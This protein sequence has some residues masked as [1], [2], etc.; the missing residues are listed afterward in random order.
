[1]I[2]SLR[3]SG[4]YGLCTRELH[5][6]RTCY[7]IWPDFSGNKNLNSETVQKWFLWNPT[8]EYTGARSNISVYLILLLWAGGRVLVAKTKKTNKH[9][10]CTIMRGSRVRSFGPRVHRSFRQLHDVPSS[11]HITPSA[12]YVHVRFH[13]VL[14][15]RIDYVLGV[16][17]VWAEANRTCS[18]PIKRI[19]KTEIQFVLLPSLAKE[20]SSPKGPERFWGFIS[21]VHPSE[22]RRRDGT[23]TGAFSPAQRRSGARVH[24][25]VCR[26]LNE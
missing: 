22:T 15:E 24:D 21:V 26:F 17:V 11:H 13:D 5:C 3:A 9:T 23:Q 6:T 7:Y 25:D 12:V 16:G 8:R 1:M 20:Q 10:R 4:P 2:K 14:H 18:V 19:E